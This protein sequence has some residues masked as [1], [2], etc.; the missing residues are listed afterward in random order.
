MKV[1][2]LV[3]KLLF[4]GLGGFY[5]LTSEAQL[6]RERI[7][8]N[9]D[10]KFTHGHPD[11]QKD[12][13]FGK[14]LSFSKIAFI[15]ESTMLEADQKSHLT[16]PHTQ[17]FDDSKWEQVSLPHDWGM[18]AGYSE[19]QFK[20]K[21]YR[22]LGGRTSDNCV[23]WYRKRFKM[24]VVK[25][26]RYHLEFEGIFRDAQIWVN[27]IFLCRHVSGYTPVELDV[28]EC[29]NYG[30]HADNV[31]TVRVDATHAE[32]WSYEGAGIY[33]NVWLT[34]TS[35]VYI[36]QWGTFVTSQVVDNGM[37]AKVK[38]DIEIRNEKSEKIQVELRQ[39]ITD[40]KGRQVADAC[41]QTE[42][43]A[44]GEHLVSTNFLVRE[45]SLWGLEDPHLYHLHSQ[46]WI[47]GKL[48]DEYNTRFGIRT[49]H[50]DADKGFFLNGKRVQIQGVCCHQDHAGVGVAVPDGLNFWRIRK[51]KEYGVNAY[52]AS[53]NPPT[54]SILDACDSLGVLVMDEMRM[55]SSSQEGLEQM[56]TVIRR[57]RNHPSVILW[58]MGNEEPALQGNEKGRLI[59]K[60][61]KAIQRKM[62]PTRLCCAAMNGSWG[63]GFTYETDVQG[64]NYYHIGNVDDIHRKFPE[65]PCILSE[66]GSTVTTRG[67]YETD[68][69]KGFHQAYDH[70]KPGWGATAQE[71]MRYIDTRPFLAGAFVWT[72]FDYGGE[73]QTHF[74]PGVVSHFGILDYCGFP[75]DAYWYYKAWWTK[76]PVLHLLPHW[77]GIG[78]DTVTVKAYTNME[79]VE[80]LLNGKSMGEQYVGKYD[81]PT[82]NVKYI[83]GK[84]TLRGLKNGKCYIETVETTG[85]PTALK[86][87]SETGDAL[88]I[89]NGDI[90]IIT[91]KVLDAK[92]RWVT[93]ASDRINF[94]V[95]N[96]LILGVGN[97]HPSSHEPDQFSEKSKAYRN[98]FGGLAQII[99]SP[100]DSGLPL[101]LIATSE[102]LSKDVMEFKIIR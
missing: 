90:A 94:E 67:I 75:K 38:A 3:F 49:I 60:R 50:F 19:N 71:W 56:K 21:G 9:K 62:D 13:N 7:S 39:F 33:R 32:L 2:I 102:S 92:K 89:G 63:N 25:G 23:G 51:L 77:N 52:R 68:A 35:S 28:T 80:L 58:C 79:K 8:L 6:L 73:A 30:N 41:Q 81:I 20:V 17:I 46:I 42:I 31:I 5:A 84:I 24:N 53:H 40:N 1:S 55:L 34:K 93:T 66:E 69:V 70:D 86:L 96:G 12:L 101:K 88:H 47:D 44:L 14:A 54:V 76:E 72:G 65:L 48:T 4:I 11:P 64:F 91:V 98:A 27:G 82:W 16:L 95:E 59:L 36:P 22:K 100:D 97:G 83:P 15:Q 26:E 45:P 10:W 29:L 99:I 85:K 18:R 61:M 37:L 57:D 43:V 87:Y 74:W 78:K